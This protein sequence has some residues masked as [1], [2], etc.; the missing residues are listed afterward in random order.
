MKITYPNLSFTQDKTTTE[1]SYLIS[2]L[3]EYK[4]YFY[5]WGCQRSNIKDQIMQL[6]ESHGKLCEL[7]VEKNI[8]SLKECLETVGVYGS[9]LNSIQIA[10]DK[11]K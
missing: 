11:E 10:N 5:E 9:V 1:L 2:Y 8:I 7:L 4:D 6:R 3:L